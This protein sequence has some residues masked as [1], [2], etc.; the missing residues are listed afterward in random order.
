[1]APLNGKQV[2]FMAAC[3]PLPISVVPVDWCG[4]RNYN[5]RRLKRSIVYSTSFLSKSPKSANLVF[6]FFNKAISFLISFGS[7]GK[8]LI[9]LGAFIRR[10]PGS[11]RFL[12]PLKILLDNLSYKRCC[13]VHHQT[14]S[15]L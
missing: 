9:V 15:I 14:E 13:R 10:P 6:I 4:Y 12:L 11:N 2:L 5:T 1:M 3:G 8:R 7:T